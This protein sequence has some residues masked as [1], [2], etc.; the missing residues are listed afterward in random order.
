MP[1][2]TLVTTIHRENGLCNAQELL[3]ILRLLEPDT[4]FEEIRPAD[5]AAYRA[6]PPPT[7]LEAQAIGK[8]LEFKH[9]QR[10]PV[11]EFELPRDR[12]LENKRELDQVFG[13]VEQASHEYSLLMEQNDGH[14]AQRGFSYLNSG[15]FTSIMARLSEI[16]DQVIALSG[17]PR[18]I[19]VLRNW[20]QTNRHRER[21]MVR[22]IYDYA[23]SN[24]LEHGVFLVGAAHKAGVATALEYNTRDEPGIISWKL[25]L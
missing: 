5:F 21:A 24:A 22:A 8:Y 23:G 1:T 12:L 19:G 13:Y 15:E 3:K 7:S 2:V 4:L 20:R 25:E 10:V 6:N 17:E 11:D 14:V 18:A 9:A 16:E